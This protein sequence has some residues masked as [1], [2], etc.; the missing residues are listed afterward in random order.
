MAELSS[1]GW[2]D[3]DC[4]W[5]LR[6]LVPRDDESPLLD[7]FRWFTL[8]NSLYRLSLLCSKAELIGSPELRYEP[9]VL[10]LRM[11]LEKSALKWSVKIEHVMVLSVD[12]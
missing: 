8:S 3:L 5:H 12:Y 10:A 1:S 7:G 9:P 6:W 11:T 2:S 4:N